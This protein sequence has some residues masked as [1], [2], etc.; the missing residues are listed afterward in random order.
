MI[1]PV[2]FHRS[3]LYS[4]SLSKERV[5]ERFRNRLL[6]PALNVCG[7]AEFRLRLSRRSR[8]SRRPLLGQGESGVAVGFLAE[9]AEQHA[10]QVFALGMAKQH[11]MVAAGTKTLEQAHPASRAAL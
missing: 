11:R 8:C 2:Q 6:Q 4:L 10:G 5:R 7:T 1:E 3:V 9:V